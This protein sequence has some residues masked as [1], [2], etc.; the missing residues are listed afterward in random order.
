[1]ARAKLTKRY[2]E[3]AGTGEH[4]DTEL[5]GFKL[6]VTSSGHKSFGIEGRMHGAKVKLTFGAFGTLTV[7]QA[8]T[9]AR[10]LL[11]DV[12]QGRDPSAAADAARKAWTVKQ[13]I[14]AYKEAHL[15][16]LSSVTQVNYAAHIER[17]I[18][19]EL[20][21][22]KAAEITAAEVL[23]LVRKA[24]SECRVVVKG[25]VIRDG[26]TSANRVLATTSSLFGEAIRQGLRSD[27]PCRS[28]RRNAEH[29]RERY[30]S[31]EETARLLAE[32]ERSPYTTVANLIRLLIHT[33]ARKGETLKARWTEF[34][35]GLGV[36]TKPSHHTKQKRTHAVPLSLAAV[37]LL[38]TM[39]VA[40]N[41]GDASPWLFPGAV[42]GEHL[43]SP[44]RAVKTIFA[45][46]GLTEGV[47]LHTLR[48]S[49]G[50]LLTS[51]GQSLHTIG[52]L[53][54]HTQAATTH[55]YAHVAHDPQREALANAGK[56]LQRAR[57]K[58]AAE[59]VES[60]PTAEIVDFAQA[61]RRH[62][63]PK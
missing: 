60:A 27:N 17:F 5:T 45:S 11:F 41:E 33:G 61:A 3:A 31:A 55:R 4:W 1:M 10:E 19:P 47:S 21:K 38:Q 20:G 40:N 26:K 13:L 34:D 56:V 46:A 23:R 51:N 14:A 43:K 44:K 35:L 53:L 39:Q 28:V 52:K 18:L 62:S 32:C 63:Q 48:H 29:K 15:P 25:V 9:R 58:Y 7:E 37:E 42:D 16:S 2:V 6:R 59:A 36:W 57:D 12:S 54:G 22:R 24:E 49:F 50:A 8:R 30:L